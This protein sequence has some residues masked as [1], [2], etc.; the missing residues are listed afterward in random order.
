M[1]AQQ[2]EDDVPLN[3][4]ILA[5]VADLWALAFR[6]SIFV[7]CSRY[8]AAKACSGLRTSTDAT[9]VAEV[10]LQLKRCTNNFVSCNLGM[11]KTL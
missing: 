8:N 5:I 10:I 3:V 1:F 2:N 4:P 11:G 9:T 6:Y 7:R